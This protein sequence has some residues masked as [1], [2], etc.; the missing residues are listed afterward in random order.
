M[1]KII[2]FP[3]CWEDLTQD[4]FIWLLKYMSD[5]RK[6]NDLMEIKLHFTDFLLG[7]RR[8]WLPCRRNGYMNLLNELAE[9]LDWLFRLEGDIILFNYDTT[10]NLLPK[11]NN[12]L[13]PLSHGA[14]LRFGEYREAVAAYNEYTTTF[15]D[16]HL[17]RL[18]GILYRPAAKKKWK[19]DF[20]GNWRIPF[21]RYS[22]G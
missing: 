2:Q 7:K 16:I 17:D 15:E 8:P 10:M 19:N 20:D 18:V 4:Q 6:V 22:I 21:N 5:G 1:K 14:D 9:S 12:L 11:V 3:E 13:G